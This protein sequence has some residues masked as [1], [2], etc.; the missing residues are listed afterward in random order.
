[1][2]WIKEASGALRQTP[3]SLGENDGINYQVLSG[4]QLGDE[5]VYSMKEEKVE[6]LSPTTEG[7]SP[8]MP[9]PPGRRSK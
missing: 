3:V 1:M 4:L 2:V 5:V 6:S 9:K 7:D 8:F